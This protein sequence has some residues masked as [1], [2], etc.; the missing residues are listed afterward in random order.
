[1]DNKQRQIKLNPT[2]RLTAMSVFSA[3]L[4][5]TNQHVLRLRTCASIFTYNGLITLELA[6]KRRRR[7]MQLFSQAY[8]GFCV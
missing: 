2:Q 6:I 5:E 4:H 7:C 1:M 8:R 3:A